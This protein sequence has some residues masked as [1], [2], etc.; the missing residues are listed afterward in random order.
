VRVNTEIN[1]WVAQKAWILSLPTEQL[2]TYQSRSAPC[3]WLV[4]G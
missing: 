3:G 4:D 2:S 1:L